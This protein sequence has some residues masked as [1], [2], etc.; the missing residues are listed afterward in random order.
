MDL[1]YNS[2]VYKLEK[3][4]NGEKVKGDCHSSI[5]CRPSLGSNYNLSYGKRRAIRELNYASSGKIY[6]QFKSRFWETNGQPT[7]SGAGIVGSTSSTDLPVRTVVYPSYY[8]ARKE[9]MFELA[10]KDIV[11][12]HGVIALKEWIPSKE[13]NKAI[14]WPNDKTAGGGALQNLDPLNL[15]N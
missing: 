2:K 3:T 13:N 10:L 4:N 7:T 1:R 12:L 9:E 8:Q 5:G 11:T 15:E 14:Y 6:L